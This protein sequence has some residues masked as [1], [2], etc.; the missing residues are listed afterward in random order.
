MQILD[1]ISLRGH[2]LHFALKVG[3][4]FSQGHEQVLGET[5]HQN[6]LLMTEKAN[7]RPCDWERCWTYL[8][9]LFVRGFL[10]IGEEK[11]NFSLIKAHLN[12]SE[13]VV[14]H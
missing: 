14:K 6:L 9:P 12:I 11:R 2:S 13:A 7:S 4:N 10:I 5:F 1:S 8:Y 3:F